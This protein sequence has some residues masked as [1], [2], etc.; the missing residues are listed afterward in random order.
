MA[1]LGLFSAVFRTIVLKVQDDR[2]YAK[3][4][5]LMRAVVLSLR[6]GYQRMANGCSIRRITLWCHAV[7]GFE[8]KKR[9]FLALFQDDRPDCGGTSR[10]QAV[11]PQR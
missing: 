1:V 9:H 5:F 11:F 6:L 8:V 2:R 3:Q 10:K 4:V 7:V